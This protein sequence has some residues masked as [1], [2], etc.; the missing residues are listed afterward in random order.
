MRDSLIQVTSTIPIVQGA[1]YSLFIMLHKEMVSMESKGQPGAAPTT[2]PLI[3][4]LCLDLY[5]VFVV[6]LP[7]HHEVA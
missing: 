5:G 3:S 1:N 4:S 6:S 2:Y 7:P